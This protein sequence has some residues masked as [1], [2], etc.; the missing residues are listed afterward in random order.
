MASVQTE[1]EKQILRNMHHQRNTFTFENG[2]VISSNFDAGN[3]WKCQQV[4]KDGK[5]DVQDE[6]KLE[7]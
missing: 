2:I 5:V 6:Q 1:I 7:I 3:L 4:N